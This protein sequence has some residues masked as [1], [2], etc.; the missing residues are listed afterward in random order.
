MVVRSK[1]RVKGRL[2]GRGRSREWKDPGCGGVDSVILGP[3]LEAG[4]AG[5]R[6]LN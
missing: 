6:M 3:H 4:A 1:R 2:T 5:Q